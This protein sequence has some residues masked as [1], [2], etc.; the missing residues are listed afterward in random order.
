MSEN[1]FDLHTHSNVS[2][3][4][5][6]P[7]EVV[8]HAARENLKLVALTDHDSIMGVTEALEAGKE[9]GIPVLPAVEM[10]NEW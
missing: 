9:F 2:D 6:T 8:A 5:A 10:D 7:R 4:T 1:R 3:G